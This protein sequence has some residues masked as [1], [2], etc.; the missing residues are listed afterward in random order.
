MGSEMCIIDSIRA[1]RV[2]LARLVTAAKGG[3]VKKIFG[4][5]FSKKYVYSFACAAGEQP[6]AFVCAISM[7]GLSSLA[8][9]PAAAGLVM[10]MA[11]SISSA[12]IARIRVR[13]RA[14]LDARRLQN[15]G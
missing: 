6:A 4:F 8:K 15:K 14:M 10:P 11:T 3:S 13:C 2:V 7:L 12:D 9:G 1:M 5:D